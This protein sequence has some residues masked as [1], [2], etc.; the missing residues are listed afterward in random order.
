M[1]IR[2]ADI[3]SKEQERRHALR[4]NFLI[5]LSSIV[6]LAVVCYLNTLSIIHQFWISL[7][8]VVVA[9]LLWRLPY[10]NH[11]RLALMAISAVTGLRFIAWRLG[12]TFFTTNLYNLIASLFLILAEFWTV[13]TLLCFYFQTI[14]LDRSQ[15][16][17][18]APDFLPT[19]DVFIA[20]YNEPLQ[21]VRRTACG[22]VSIDYPNK[23][24]YILDD[25]RSQ[26]LVELADELDCHYITRPDNK[27][28]KAGN[29]NNALGQTDGELILFLDA[30][31][32]PC[33]SIL[34]RTVP[35][36]TDPT[37]A[38]VQAAHRFM[39]PGPIERNLF[40][41]GKVPHEQELFFQ[42][43]QVGK[44]F[45]NATF[46]AGSAAVMR[47]SALNKVGGMV[48]QTVA[49]DCEISVKL[50][51][52]GYRSEYV[53]DPMII[54]LNPEGLSEY[55]IQQSRWSR[56]SHQLMVLE[57]PLFEKGLS[58]PQKIC[59]FSGMAHYFFPFPRLIYTA[60]PVAYLCLNMYPL[61]IPI[62]HYAIMAIP[63]LLLILLSNNYIF[64][65]YRHSFWSDVYAAVVAPLLANHAIRTIL[66][67]KN[68]K[69]HVTPK[70][71]RRNRLQADL[72]DVFPNLIILLICALAIFAAL[73]RLL[74]NIGPPSS[75]L[76]NLLW[77]IYNMVI[78]FTAVLV[79]LQPPDVR[80][81]HRARASLPVT[82]RA[83]DA[84]EPSPG[85]TLDINE[86]GAR[87]NVQEIN[88]HLKFGSEVTV[89][90]VRRDDTLADYRAIVRATPKRQKNE[91]IVELEFLDVSNKELKTLVDLVYCDARTWQH[92]REP[93]DSLFRSLVTV[94]T[95]PIRVFSITT[96]LDAKAAVRENLLALGL[97]DN[98]D[99]LLEWIKRQL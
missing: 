64:Q 85:I 37:L 20:T 49:E 45:W 70:G 56:G 12:Y 6:S 31:H 46:F 62:P 94:L 22:A 43:V 91:Q 88:E 71:L 89:T 23:R 5:V 18:E 55:L 76:I 67:P 83:D 4:I 8:V 77:N 24:V 78:I 36:F 79:G 35:Y 3:K 93:K 61:S 74:F 21:I 48:A 26:E 72:S 59:Y 68:A 30:D 54:G 60:M 7:V 11:V 90:F 19:V 69:F 51:A 86:F 25:G 63:Y 66:K 87:V 57:N 39:N 81:A 27:N 32:I 82:I 80:R 92:I 42:L 53:A 41:E 2:P 99:R 38:F 28:Y 84:A 58:L 65:N 15:R 33:N 14:V 50:H 73:V 29:I 34:R 17:I 96:Y 16:M 97:P 47:R 1:A 40:T 95:S 44:N 52:I 98:R 10:N 9:A 13:M 75:T